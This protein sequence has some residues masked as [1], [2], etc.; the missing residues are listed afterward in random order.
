MQFTDL[1]KDE[2]TFI[3]R[4]IGNLPTESNAWP[5]HQKLLMQFKEQAEAEAEAAQAEAVQ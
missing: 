3:L 5:L 1:S 2:A 4:V